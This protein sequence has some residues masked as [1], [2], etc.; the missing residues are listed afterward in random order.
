MQNTSHIINLSNVCLWNDK[1]IIYYLESPITL[2]YFEYIMIDTDFITPPMK[3][4]YSFIKSIFIINN[5]ICMI[6]KSSYYLS[7]IKQILGEDITLDYAMDFHNCYDQMFPKEETSFL[8]KEC[9]CM[10]RNHEIFYYLDNPLFCTKFNYI[11]LDEQYKMSNLDKYYKYIKSIFHIDDFIVLAITNENNINMIKSFIDDTIIYEKY[12]D[13]INQCCSD[14]LMEDSVPIVIGQPNMFSDY[15]LHGSPTESTLDYKLHNSKILWLKSSPLEFKHFEYIVLFDTSILTLIKPYDGY[16][17]SIFKFS[18]SDKIVCIFE[19]SGCNILILT[20][21]KKINGKIEFMEAKNIM[22]CYYYVVNN[23]KYDDLKWDIKYEIM[24]YDKKVSESIVTDYSKHNFSYNS[25]YTSTY[26]S[27]HFENQFNHGNETIKYYFTDPR[28]CNNFNYIIMPTVEK[29]VIIELLRSELAKYVKSFFVV[30]RSKVLIMEET[31]DVNTIIGVI[32]EI[33]PIIGFASEFSEC[34]NMINE[35]I[36][37]GNDNPFEDMIEYNNE[38]KNTIGLTLQKP[39]IIILD[40]KVENI[41]DKKVENIS[42]KKEI[43]QKMKEIRDF[44]EESQKKKKDLSPER[45]FS[46]EEFIEDEFDIDLINDDFNTTDIYYVAIYTSKDISFFTKIF[47]DELNLN[48]DF[49]EEESVMIIMVNDDDTL[50]VVISML[51]KIFNPEDNFISG[52]C[53]SLA[54]CIDDINLKKKMMQFYDKT[55]EEK[56]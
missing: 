8:G 55:L 34:C 18:N 25:N 48:V 13:N 51:K 7:S 54:I 2:K 9:S 21:I 24:L 40:K 12:A 14:I 28:K 52:V 26:K 35:I 15:N 16:F 17:T 31:T 36:G 49:F 6:V 37:V 47:I 4:C 23:L 45:F 1:K 46:D 43:D 20:E 30:N 56:N 29:Q 39:N 44:Y 50:N 11:V 10:W 19:K 22:E 38:L 41:P 32:P 53:G 5:K 33:E 42:D 3:K 27:T